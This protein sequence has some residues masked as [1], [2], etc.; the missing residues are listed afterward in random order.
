MIYDFI[1]ELAATK[2]V[3]AASFERAKAAFGLEGVIEAASC[4]GLYGMI[5][6]VL[7][8]FERPA[9]ARHPAVLIGLNRSFRPQ[10]E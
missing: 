1:T 3:S 9:A 5:G 7:N 4:A 8:V 6:Y 10:R 2:T